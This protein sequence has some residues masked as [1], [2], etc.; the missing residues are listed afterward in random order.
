MTFILEKEL[1]IANI[2]IFGKKFL[3]LMVIQNMEYDYH[4][5]WTTISHQI[6]VFPMKREKHLILTLLILGGI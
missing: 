4:R 2:K 1:P 5:L 6:I 3:L